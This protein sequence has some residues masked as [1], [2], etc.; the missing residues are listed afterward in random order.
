MGTGRAEVDGCGPRAVAQ[1][2]KP[3]RKIAGRRLDRTRYQSRQEAHETMAD[4]GLDSLN[5]TPQRI[6]LE[7]AAAL[8]EA[9]LGRFGDT[10]EARALRERL[11]KF[12]GIPEAPLPA[13]VKADLRPYQKEGFSFLCH[14][15][16]MKLGGI[17]AD[18]MGLGKLYRR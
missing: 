5:V 14:L 1:F 11:S 12:E 13:S 17:L 6:G 3:V 18:D 2:D 9:R 7:Q 16:E 15:T 8:D 10:A 4:L